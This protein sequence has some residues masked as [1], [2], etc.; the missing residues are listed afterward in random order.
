MADRT[1]APRLPWSADEDRIVREN[2][3]LIPAA[4]IARMIGR[5]TKAVDNHAFNLGLSNRGD[6]RPWTDADLAQLRD[7]YEQMPAE[8]VAA[9]TGRTVTS[10]RRRAARMGYSKLQVSQDQMRTALQ[11]FR[12]AGRSPQAGFPMASAPVPPP[13]A[14]PAGSAMPRK[15]FVSEGRVHGYFGDITSADQAYVLGLLAADGNVASVHPRVSLGLV[16]KDMRAV[17]FVRDRLNPAAPLSPAASGMM[18]L[19]ISSRQMVAD[20]ARFGIVPRKSRTLPWPVQLD[21][22]QRPFLLGYF[23]GDGSM[24]LPRDRD[25]RERPGWNVCSGS[26]KFLIAMR[27][28]VLAATGVKLQE[29][30]HRASADLWQVSV[31]G[32]GAVVVDEWLHQEGIGLARKRFPE[33]VL[34]YYRS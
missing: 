33:Q 8:E 14:Y 30:Q 3:G 17:E 12:A 20:L 19:Q 4:Q 10:V 23:D 15:T 16:A 5:T 27:E 26:E 34:T 32:L 6:L 7:L 22:L 24:F 13:L 21:E 25:G 31:T 2:Y 1:R 11:Q 29:I 28:Y 9:L 18:V